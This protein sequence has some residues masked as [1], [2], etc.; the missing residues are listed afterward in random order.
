MGSSQHLI[1]THT[2]RAPRNVDCAVTFFRTHPFG[3]YEVYKDN[4][5]VDGEGGN[6]D[7]D[8]DEIMLMATAMEKVLVEVTAMTTVPMEMITVVATILMTTMMRMDEWMVVVGETKMVMVLVAMTVVIAVVMVTGG[9]GDGAGHSCGEGV[10]RGEGGGDGG[11]DDGTGA[12]DDN[13]GDADGYRA[14]EGERGGGDG[15]GA[16][17]DAKNHKLPPDA[18]LLLRGDSMASLPR[19]S[20]R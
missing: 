18:C 6:G 1:K 7:D 14:G 12:G 9:G 11:D 13:D 8:A 15:G 17:E 3:E 5:S 2:K 19:S 4:G 16:G 10:G 20:R